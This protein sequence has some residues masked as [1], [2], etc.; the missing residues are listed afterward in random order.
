[1]TAHHPTEPLAPR[2]GSGG[3]GGNSGRSRPLPLTSAVR[4]NRP[5][6][7][8]GKR[9]GRRIAVIRRRCGDRP[10]QQPVVAVLTTV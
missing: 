7:G 1:M 2:P 6:V 4:R 10:D 3:F 5:F 8:R 9:R